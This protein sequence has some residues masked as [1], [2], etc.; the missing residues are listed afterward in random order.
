MLFRLNSV[1]NQIT[2]SNFLEL[3]HDST[4]TNKNKRRKST[5]TFKKYMEK[6]QK[7]HQNNLFRKEFTM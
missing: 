6:A 7:Q 3:Y 2:L 4:D 1:V 5:E